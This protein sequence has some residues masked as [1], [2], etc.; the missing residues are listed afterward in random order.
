MCLCSYNAYL[1]VCVRV[2][3]RG[4]GGARARA[5]TCE[6]ER[7]RLA[8]SLE[9]DWWPDRPVRPTVPAS[10][11]RLTESG[12]ARRRRRDAASTR[13]PWPDSR[14]WTIDRSVHPPPSRE[15]YRCSPSW[16]SKNKFSSF[17][18]LS[19]KFRIRE[20][21]LSILLKEEGFHFVDLC[22]Y[23]LKNFRT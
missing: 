16:M 21:F 3:A 23:N 2:R 14:L 22:D 7:E 20:S 15:M 19:G 6:R 18:F 17:S 1:C 10:G 8:G 4:R 11:R 9:A 13:P 5:S 12:D